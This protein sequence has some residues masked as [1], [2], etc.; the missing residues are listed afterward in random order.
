M[1]PLFCS[2]GDNTFRK[3]QRL[4]NLRR[5]RSCRAASN[6]PLKPS[7]L[8]NMHYGPYLPAFHDGSG[9]QAMHYENINCSTEWTTVSSSLHPFSHMILGNYRPAI[10]S[11]GKPTQTDRYSLGVVLQVAANHIVPTAKLRNGEDNNVRRAVG[12]RYYVSKVG[13]LSISFSYQPGL[14]HLKE[15][16]N[17]MPT[18]M[19]PPSPYLVN[20]PERNQ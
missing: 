3:P 9:L 19:N 14:L 11:G 6:S 10:C 8:S 1:G 5:T 18:F 2:A 15:K 17:M 12:S 13:P 20:V 7:A 4:Q 16:V